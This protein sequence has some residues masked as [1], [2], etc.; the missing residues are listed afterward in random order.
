MSK[1]RRIALWW[2]TVVVVCSI[3]ILAG[4]VYVNNV[5]TRNTKDLTATVMPGWERSTTGEKNG[6]GRYVISYTNKIGD[7]AKGGESLMFYVYHGDVY[8]YSEGKLM[9]SMYMDKSNSYFKTV[10]GDAWNCIFISEEMA[11]K[12]IEVVVHTDYKSYL[13]YEPVFYLGDRMTIVKNE[14]ISG[15][16]N[17]LVVFVMFFVGIVV[18]GYSLLS[19]RNRTNS[20]SLV[21]LGIFAVLLSVWF[22]VNMPLFNM[23]FD[24][25]T[26]LTYIS[27][28]ILGS[29]TVPLV[30]FEKRLMETKYNRI[31]D[32]VC[33]ANMV[34]QAVLV[35]FQVINFMDMKDTLVFFHIT[36]GISVL[37]LVALLIVDFIT[38]GWKNLN[39]ISKLNMLC[40]LFTALGVGIDIVYFYIDVNASRQY[41]FTKLTFL[42]HIILLCYYSMSETQKLMRKGR[43][44]QKY[45]KLAYVDDLTGVLN[46]TAYHNDMKK[47]DIVENLYTVFMFDL[48]NLKVCNDLLGHNAGDDYIKSCA[49]YIR[50]S[51]AVLGKCYRIGGDEFC[52]IAKDIDEKDIDACYEQMQKRIDEYNEVNP[53]VNMSVACGYAVYDSEQDEDLKDTRGRADK[54]MYKNKIEMKTKAIKK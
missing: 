30:L 14:L 15:L 42:V 13:E 21:Y 11:N 7:I 20:Y 26:I 22:L 8:V 28:I 49:K 16:L 43:E 33:I 5:R 6:E 45:E 38:V 48:N 3:L 25:G 35:I 12:D 54:V 37:I 32:I 31:C 9:Y 4:A 2:L 17:L 34:V 18:I 1:S 51:F 10:S 47:M 44:A 36:I 29:I 23:I 24:N 41:I 53:E 27:Y 52:V 50:D 19:S 40:G 46:R 39:G